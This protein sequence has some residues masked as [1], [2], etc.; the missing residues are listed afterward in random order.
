MIALNGPDPDVAFLRGLH[1]GADVETVMY[2]QPRF[3][4]SQ[5]RISLGRLRLPEQ[6]DELLDVVTACFRKAMVVH[7]SAMYPLFD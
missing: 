3:D 6:D 1:P 5:L 4:V 7:H 2:P